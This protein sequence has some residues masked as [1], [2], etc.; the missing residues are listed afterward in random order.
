MAGEKSG[1]VKVRRDECREGHVGVM[2]RLEEWKER[3]GA[4]SHVTF[5]MLPTSTMKAVPA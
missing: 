5:R 3:L 4:K 1:R 2:L